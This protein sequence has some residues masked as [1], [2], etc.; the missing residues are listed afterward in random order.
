MQLIATYQD[1]DLVQ[2]GA[3]VMGFFEERPDLHSSGASFGGAAA[4]NPDKVHR[5]L[6]GV[7]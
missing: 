3:R 2:L 7:A 6:P 1:G 4:I 5:Y